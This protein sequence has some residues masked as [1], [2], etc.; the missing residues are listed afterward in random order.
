M[1]AKKAMKIKAEE[2]SK[3]LEAEMKQLPFT[4]ANDHLWQ[5]MIWPSKRNETFSRYKWQ[6]IIYPFSGIEAIFWAWTQRNARECIWLM[7]M[8]SVFIICFN[9]HRITMGIPK[10]CVA[11]CVYELCRKQKRKQKKSSKRFNV[12][13]ICMVSACFCSAACK[14]CD[15]VVEFVCNNLSTFPLQNVLG[16]VVGPLWWFHIPNHCIAWGAFQWWFEWLSEL[17]LLLLSLLF[18]A[19]WIESCG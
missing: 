18:L 16:L 17:P 19:Q 8:M 14:L 3:R 5:T 4:N 11:E 13:V 9:S 7:E 12:N 1:K 2:K 6:S 10:K 15:F